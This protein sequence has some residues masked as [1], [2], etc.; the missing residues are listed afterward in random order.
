MRKYFDN[1]KRSVTVSMLFIAKLYI[2]T[3][4]LGLLYQFKCRERNRLSSVKLL[5]SRGIFPWYNSFSGGPIMKHNHHI[6]PKWVILPRISYGDKLFSLKQEWRTKL[7]SLERE[8]VCR[9][10]NISLCAF[11]KYFQS[12]SGRF[13]KQNK[14]KKT[15]LFIW[16]GI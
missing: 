4:F 2:T 11:L 13:H 12:W 1:K 15:Q 16:L 6:F 9:V 7:F 8:D 5:N 14:T 3:E 10:A